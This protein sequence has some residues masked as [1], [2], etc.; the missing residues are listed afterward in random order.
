[1]KAKLA[2]VPLTAKGLGKP[3]PSLN[4]LEGFKPR[5]GGKAFLSQPTVWLGKA[6]M[7]SEL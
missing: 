1:M 7:G 2:E 5:V 4:H 6:A 3:V